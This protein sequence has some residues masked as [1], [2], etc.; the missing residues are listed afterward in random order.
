M[1]QKLICLVVQFVSGFILSFL[2][3]LIR[4]FSGWFRFCLFALYPVF[5][6]LSAYKIV[7]KGVNPY[8][9]WILPAAAYALCG[10]A[11]TFGIAPDPAPFFISFLTA[12]VGSAAG[13]EMNKMNIKRKSHE[14]K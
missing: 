13:D 1:K 10:L 6:F 7:R 4:P 2:F 5:S 8:T 14:K 9:A 12:L 11:V 3:F